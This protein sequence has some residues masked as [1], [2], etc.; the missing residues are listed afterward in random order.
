LL[1]FTGVSSLPE[2]NPELSEEKSNGCIFAL[3]FSRTGLVL[4]LRK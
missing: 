2:N 3:D 1:C 4:L